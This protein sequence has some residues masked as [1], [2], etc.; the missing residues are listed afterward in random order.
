MLP[1]I[2]ILGGF[3]FLKRPRS[4][5]MAIYKRLLPKQ[6]GCGVLGSY[7]GDPYDC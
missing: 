3:G 5:V 4:F 2:I 7:R 1:V 6:I